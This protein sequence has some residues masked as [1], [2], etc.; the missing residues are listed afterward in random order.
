MLGKLVENIE[1]LRKSEEFRYK[2]KAKQINDKL[3]VFV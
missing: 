3:K 2:K 1:I